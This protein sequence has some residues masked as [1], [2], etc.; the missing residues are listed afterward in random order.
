MPVTGYL[1][2]AKEDKVGITMAIVHANS[3]NR[4]G[5]FAYLLWMVDHYKRAMVFE[6]A[7]IIGK[8]LQNSLF[9][10]LTKSFQ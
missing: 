9:D 5:R 7:E 10:F 4:S 8:S 1:V 3:K 2:K 6:S